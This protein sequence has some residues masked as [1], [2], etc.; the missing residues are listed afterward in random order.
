MTRQLPALQRLA[1]IGALALVAGACAGG[2]AS[3]PPSSSASASAGT[4]AAS[5]PGDAVQVVQVR[6][7]D[8]LRYEPDPIRV[9]PGKVRFEVT[10]AGQ[11]VHEFFVG[12]EAQQ[13]EHEAEMRGGHG[14]GDATTLELEGGQSGT[15]EV[16]FDAPGETLVGCHEPGHYP[17]G[18]KA[19]IIVEG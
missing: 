5:P 4:P 18:M 19:R 10:N 12:T 14:H 17:G 15:L 13:D 9:R 16:T 11:A 2:G 1:A 8:T 6:M 3:A 7:L